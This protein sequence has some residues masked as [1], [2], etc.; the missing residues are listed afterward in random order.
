MLMSDIKY[1]CQQ[2]KLVHTT[3]LLGYPPPSVR[4]NNVLYLYLCVN[5]PKSGSGDMS[6]SVEHHINSCRYFD[7]CLY[8]CYAESAKFRHHDSIAR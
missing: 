8:L 2:L 4:S 5:K 1:C 3:H 7:R 6:G